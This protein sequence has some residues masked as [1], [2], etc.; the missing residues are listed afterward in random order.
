M[1]SSR[2][3]TSLL[4]ATASLLPFAD[5][6]FA[7][8]SGFG[9]AKPGSRQDAILNG[10]ISV[11]RQLRLQGVTPVCIFDLDATLF[12]AGGRHKAIMTEFA[13]KNAR[14]YPGMLPAVSEWV[15]DQLPYEL[16]EI[17]PSI[18][19][20]TIEERK[21]ARAFWQERF[22]TNE[23]LRHDVPIAGS[24]RYIAALSRIGCVI[25]YLTGR[26]DKEMR[27]GTLVTLE[28]A[29]FP[30]APDKAT[31]IMTPV[32]GMRDSKFKG[33]PEVHET[34]TKLGRVVAIFDNE[35]GNVNELQRSFPDA[36][37]VFLDTNHSPGA[38]PVDTGIAWIKNFRW[39]QQER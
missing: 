26:N 7:R 1:P 30:V 3:I 16:T 15:T 8:A 23:Y 12:D 37:T 17:F 6:Q 27:P 14:R 31:L 35:P 20:T 5:P 9:D 36:F 13:K 33:S 39:S 2:V 24:L 25:V 38:P 28:A 18:G 19:L 32:R 34:I 10:V 11:S 21:R 4:A 29:G 22:F